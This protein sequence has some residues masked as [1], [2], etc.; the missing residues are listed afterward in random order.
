MKLRFICGIRVEDE[1][2]L[3]EFFVTQVR[4]FL[5]LVDV[6]LLNSEMMSAGEPPVVPRD[7]FFLVRAD[8]T[9]VLAVE[10]FLVFRLFTLWS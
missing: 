1:L 9:A 2:W 6:L 4:D 7:A 5:N 10:R 3:R 8:V